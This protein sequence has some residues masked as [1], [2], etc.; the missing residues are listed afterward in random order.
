LVPEIVGLWKECMLVNVDPSRS[1][2]SGQ[3]A[4]VHRAKPSIFA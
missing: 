2:D 1:S 4:E 3:L